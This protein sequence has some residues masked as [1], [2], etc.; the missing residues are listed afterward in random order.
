[1]D[2]F[3]EVLHIPIPL[4]AGLIALRRSRKGRFGFRERK[5]SQAVLIGTIMETQRS[6]NGEIQQQNYLE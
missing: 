2:R 4:I 5:T 1:M 6:I 3:I